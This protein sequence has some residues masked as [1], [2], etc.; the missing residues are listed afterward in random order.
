MRKSKELNNILDECLER[1]LLKGESIE[2]CL[3]R[4]PDYADKLKPLL[5]T[6]L[7]AS[8][9][10]QVQPRSEFKAKAR[11]EFRLALQAK[12]KRGRGFFSWQPVWATAVAAVLTIV[13]AG[14]ATVGAAGNSMPDT[15]LYPVK[16]TTEQVQLTLT[17][18]PLGKAELHAKLADRRVAEIIYLANKGKP[19]QMELTTNRLNTCLVRIAVLSRARRKAVGG[20]EVLAPPR[21]PAEQARGERAPLMETP[22]QPRSAQDVPI[23]RIRARAELRRKL[24]HY[25][26]NHPAALRVALKRAPKS[27]EHAL[28]R[29]IAVS[30]AGYREATEA[31]D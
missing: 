3:Q 20:G 4:Y 19:E 21:A 28:R 29:A 1:L 5:D 7:S 14:G 22:R 26:T 17:R 8:K 27:V 18:S 12:T 16:V 31:L 25:A 6:I 13:L 23:E 30:E 24:A 9:A 15:L 10:S 11:Y 2:Q